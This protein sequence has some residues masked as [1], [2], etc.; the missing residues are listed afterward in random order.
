MA[1]SLFIMK[2]KMDLILKG[3]LFSILNIA[4]TLNGFPVIG[5]SLGLIAVVYF[6][7]A[8]TIRGK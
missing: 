4:F 5:I 6:I 8:L 1:A 2:E 3:Y 7:K